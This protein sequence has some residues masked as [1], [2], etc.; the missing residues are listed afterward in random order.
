MLFGNRHTAYELK[1]GP[2]AKPT[3]KLRDSIST[4]NAP[5]PSTP[6]NSISASMHSRPKP[7]SYAFTARTVTSGS[8]AAMFSA[9]C[10]AR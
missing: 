8:Y 4:N 3:S 5:P 2:D 10:C 6:Q 1:V 7:S 9:I